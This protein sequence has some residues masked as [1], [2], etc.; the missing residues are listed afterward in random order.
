MKE[1]S[2]VIEVDSEKCINCHACIAACPVKYCNDGSGDHVT[3]NENLCIGCGNCITACT[4]DARR[5]ID[6]YSKWIEAVRSNEKMIAVSA[7][8]IASNFPDTYKNIHGW[9]KSLGVEDFFDVSFGAELTVKSYIEYIRSEK[10]Q[11][12]IAQPCPAIVSYIELY[13]KD[14]IPYL[15]PADSPMLHS[16]KMIREYYPE[17]RNHKVLVL[18][19]CL[20]KRRE[21]DATGFGDYNLTYASLLEHLKKENINPK[22]FPEVAYTV[23]KAERAVAFSSPGGLMRTVERENQ[24]AASHTR[25]IEGPDIVYE[26]L[27]KLQEMIEKGAS[28]L[29]VDCLN[30]EMGCNGGPGTLN[31][32]KSPDEIEFHIEKRNKEMQ[33]RYRKKHILRSKSAARRRVRRDI[34]KYWKEGLYARAYINRSENNTIVQPTKAEFQELY[35]RMRKYEEKDFLNCRACGYGSCESMAVAIHNNLNQPENCF[36]YAHASRIEMTNMIFD[37]IRETTDRLSSVIE[38]L[39]KKNE[40]EDDE[41]VSIQNI[42]EISRGMRASIDDGLE[43]IK[44]T[45]NTMEEIRDSNNTTAERTNVLNDQIKKIGDIVGIIS[46]ITD[47]TKI[48]AFNAELEASSAGE[49]SRNFEIVAAEIRR[50]ANST[51]DSTKQIKDQINE[52]QS[53]SKQL[54]KSREEEQNSIARGTEIANNLNEVFKRLSDYSA[55]T[56]KKIDKWM[57]TQIGSFE[58]TLEELRALSK[59][60]DEFRSKGTH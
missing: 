45:I 43:Y 4:H 12:L 48:I 8:A 33:E 34:N 19:P 51:G 2:K 35:S 5:G 42:A 22:S 1:Q 23:D 26:Y 44:N 57:E 24:E 41:M 10:P 58:Q 30:C 32:E 39:S 11:T 25:K 49:N 9:L 53:S 3:V 56:D 29:L 6:D 14:L 31:Q 46:S 55:E 60:M 18:S 20:A 47:Q 52:I 28:P 50:L 36:H 16:V 54:A 40:N 59:Q 15:A 13:R 38:N 21:F 17:Y 37:S 27:D 7:P